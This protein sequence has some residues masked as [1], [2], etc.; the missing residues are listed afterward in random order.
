MRCHTAAERFRNDVDGAIR[1]QQRKRFLSC[2]KKT[3]HARRTVAGSITGI[4]ENKYVDTAERVNRFRDIAAIQRTAGIAMCDQYARRG[5]SLHRQVPADDST[6]G[7]APGR[8]TSFPG[9]DF[10]HLRGKLR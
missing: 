2:R 8:E 5:S 9:E 10:S 1:W 3:A 6:Y 7:V 4:F